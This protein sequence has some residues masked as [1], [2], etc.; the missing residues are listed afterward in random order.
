MTS[1]FLEDF[2]RVTGGLFLPNKQDKDVGPGAEQFFKVLDVGDVINDR[3]LGMR[4]GEY[5][6][7]RRDL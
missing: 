2:D 1:G 3:R 5:T 4:F 7:C 6:N